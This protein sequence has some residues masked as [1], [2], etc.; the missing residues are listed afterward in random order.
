MRRPRK[1]SASSDVKS[2][3]TIP[4]RLTCVKKLA[5]TAKY[6]AA[7]PSARSTFPYGLSRPSNATEPTTSKDTGFSYE[8]LQRAS[9][10]GRLFPAKRVWA[11]NRKTRPARL[12]GRYFETIAES[13]FLVAAGTSLG[14][15][16]SACLRAESHLHPRLAGSPRTA[17]RST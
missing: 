9:A 12:H 7:P 11:K 5:A 1:I 2:S 17:S 10:A 6:V 14:S 4:T 16:K 3:P 13:R 8:L 15:V